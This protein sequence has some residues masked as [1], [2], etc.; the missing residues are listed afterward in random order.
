MS[1]IYTRCA[2]AKACPYATGV[3]MQLHRESAE[4]A[5]LAKELRL[6]SMSFD[7]AN[8]TPERM[9]AYSTLAAE[10]PTAAPWHFVTTR[11]QAELQPILDGLRPGR[12]QEAKPARPNRPAESHP[13]RLPHRSRRQHPQHLQLR[14]ARPAPRARRCANAD[15]GVGASRQETTHA[16]SVRQ[17]NDIKML[18]MNT[19]MNPNKALWEKGD[20]TRIAAS[21][22]ESGEA[23]VHRL[24]IKPGMKVLDLGCGD[25]T[26][27]LPA[28]KLGA[29]VL[30][31]D[32]ASNLVE[33]G[34]RR[35]KEHGPHELPVSGR[36]C[37]QSARA[38][39]SSRLISS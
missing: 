17:H 24:G 15:D 9:A 33:A 14:H 1:F 36:R 7:P 23:L 4:D 32:I 21:M 27:A 3:L 25:G 13:A 37:D 31:V 16:P 18:Q 20:F 34:N 30:G 38:G 19:P 5:A 12:G 6:V 26:T 2:A 8:D 10:R 28:A 29:D 22:R 39:R 35:A 11:S